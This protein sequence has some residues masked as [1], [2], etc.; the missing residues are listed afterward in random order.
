MERP[1]ALRSGNEL[2][3]CSVHSPEVNWLSRIFLQFL[4][5]LQNMIVYSAG[6]RIVLISPNLIQKFFARDHPL[7][8]LHKKL[9]YFKLLGSH[10]NSLSAAHYLHLGEIHRNI[11]KTLSS[12]GSRAARPSHRCPHSR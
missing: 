8:V 2:V 6:G 12:R 9:K 3:A 7:G 11:A 1:H 5:Q 10:G 4:S